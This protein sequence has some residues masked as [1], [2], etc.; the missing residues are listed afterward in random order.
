MRATGRLET[1][2]NAGI[3]STGVASHSIQANRS[4]I[5]FVLDYKRAV[6]VVV[7]PGAPYPEKKLEFDWRSIKF[8]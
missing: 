7:V 2:T 1:V 3:H 5:P 6:G 8:K 4:R